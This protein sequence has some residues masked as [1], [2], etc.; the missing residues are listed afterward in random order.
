MNPHA[1]GLWCEEQVAQYL[2]CVR[3]WRILERRVRFKG[4]EV[5]LIAESPAQE[6][7]FVEVK[8]RR[9]ERF[10]SPLE[11]MTETKQSRF[12]RTAWEWKRRKKE[13][14]EARFLFYSVELQ[15]GI[16]LLDCYEF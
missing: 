12:Y 7:F 14:R 13:W 2:E 5:D 16:P 9:N 11:A 4:G 10:G 1:F 8:G 6:L 3:G 15:E